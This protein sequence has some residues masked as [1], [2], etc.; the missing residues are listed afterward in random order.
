MMTRLLIAAFVA[1]FAAPAFAEPPAKPSSDGHK[2]FISSLTEEQRACIA[3]HNCPK[4]KRLADNDAPAADDPDRRAGIEC[5]K[6]AFDD[7]GIAMPERGP[8]P[9]GKTPPQPEK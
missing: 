1:V 7:C 4:P 2:G 6:K 3:T 8:R 9:D 5:M